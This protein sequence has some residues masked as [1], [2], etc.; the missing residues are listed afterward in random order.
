[1]CWASNANHPPS[2]PGQAS[3]TNQPS[4]LRRQPVTVA[5]RQTPPVNRTR[6]VRPRGGLSHPSG[7]GTLIST[8]RSSMPARY[9]T[10]IR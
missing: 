10:P 1:M 5:S 2:D 3:R 9:R 6:A 7:S 4:A 8:G